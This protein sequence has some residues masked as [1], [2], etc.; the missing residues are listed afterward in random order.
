MSD[1]EQLSVT[2]LELRKLGNDMAA[3]A[4]KLR[5]CLLFSNKELNSLK[6]CG[7]RR[8]HACAQM[9]LD[10]AVIDHELSTTELKYLVHSQ[11][12]LCALEAVAHLN[13]I[14]YRLSALSAPL[15]TELLSQTSVR[16]IADIESH[17]RIIMGCI[18]HAESE[19]VAVAYKR[20]L[21]EQE[22]F[23]CDRCDI[24]SQRPPPLIYSDP[25]LHVFPIG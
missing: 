11:K 4:E 18:S 5:A 20:D 1:M 10:S 6:K 16:A 14:R 24:I 25:C 15:A 3:R 23:K 9:L 19:F 13:A 17:A 22:L 21:L 2:H 12:Y 7:N 8:A